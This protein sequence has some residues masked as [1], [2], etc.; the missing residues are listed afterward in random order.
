MSDPAIRSCDNINESGKEILSR[1]NVS[2]LKKPWGM[3]AAQTRIPAANSAGVLGKK[4]EHT[5][6][7]H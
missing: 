7:Q 3:V 2:Y 6:N 4:V 1:V 5:N